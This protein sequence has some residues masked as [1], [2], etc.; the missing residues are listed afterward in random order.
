MIDLLQ[1]WSVV[2]LAMG[3]ALSRN[4]SENGVAWMTG[5]GICIALVGVFFIVYKRLY[6][7]GW[8]IAVIGG[9][10]I[11]LG[12][13]QNSSL[14]GNSI[15]TPNSPLI[16]WGIVIALSGIGTWAALRSRAKAQ[17]I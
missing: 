11:M 8:I 6:N 16:I 13:G 12:G 17:L 1:R 9:S 14:F 10:L 15:Q 5:V 4:G 7:L 2:I 3:L